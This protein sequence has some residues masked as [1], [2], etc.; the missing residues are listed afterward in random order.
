VVQVTV[1]Q[2]SGVYFSTH[3]N[4]CPVFDPHRTTTECY[5]RRYK[6][7]GNIQS[8]DRLAET[9]R[10]IAT[11]RSRATTKFLELYSDFTPEDKVHVLKLFK[12]EATAEL[13]YQ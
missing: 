7:T 3:F 9:A 2:D 12:N 6:V 5:D 8:I 1:G 11:F 13:F 4:T 10:E